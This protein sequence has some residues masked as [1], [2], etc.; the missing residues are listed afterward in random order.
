MTE[1]V[2]RIESYTFEMC[3][4]TDTKCAQ[5]VSDEMMRWAQ[6]ESKDAPDPGRLDDQTSKYLQGIVK[7]MADCMQRAL[8][9]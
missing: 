3:S 6:A 5:G 1:A 2:H 7:T 4:C 8:S 9:H